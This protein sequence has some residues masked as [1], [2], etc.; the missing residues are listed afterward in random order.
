MGLNDCHS[1]RLNVHL[2]A[3]QLRLEGKT[4][5]NWILSLYVDVHRLLKTL[6]RN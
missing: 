2:K 1:T 5:W 3:S 4:L 6:S